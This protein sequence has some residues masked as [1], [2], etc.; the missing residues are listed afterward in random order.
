MAITKAQAAGLS[1]DMLLGGVIETIVKESA[2][3]S[4][5]PFM[6]VTGTA[7][8]YNREV[9]MPDVNFYA[10]GDTSAEAT[11]TFTKA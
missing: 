10:S 4:F 5:L 6:E 7:L 1:N 11:P 3:L 8:S 2:I 9:T